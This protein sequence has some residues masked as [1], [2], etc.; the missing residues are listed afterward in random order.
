MDPGKGFRDNGLYAEIERRQR[1]VLAGG[2][3]TVVRPAEDN[4]LAQFLRP[5][6]EFGI[7]RREAV[8]RYLRNVR[9]EGKYLRPRG[10]YV[11]RGD[12]VAHLEGAFAGDLVLQRRGFRIILD[13][14]T[15]Q[16]FDGRCV[17]L[18]RRRNY[19]I[20]VH[21]EQLRDLEF[22]LIT[23]LARIGETAKHGGRRGDLGGDEIDL[24]VFRPAAA[25]E[26]PVERPE[27]YPAGVRRL[28]HADAG[29]A[30]AFKN[31][32]AALDH[33]IERAV[34]RYHVQYLLRS[35]RDGERHVR[36]NGLSVED[37]RHL[38]HI[39]KGTVGAGTDADLIDLHTGELRDL[40]HVI[41]RMRARRHGFE[42]RQI[43]LDRPVV[44]RAVVRGKGSVVALASFRLEETSRDL[45]RR[46]DRSR[47]AELGA[48][49]CDGRPLGNGKST[50]ALSGI[51]DYITDAA[52]DAHNPENFEDNVLG[53]YPVPEFSAEF[54]VYD[55]RV[56]DI[57]RAAAHS[58]RHVETARADGKHADAAAGGRVAVGADQRLARH[59]EAFKMDLVADAVS[60]SAEVD[61][62]LLRDGS[63]ES[64]V[65]SIFKAGLERVVV[66]VRD[67]FLRPDAW[68]PH[69]LE[70]Q[71]RHGAGGVLCQ[72]LVDPETD[73]RPFFAYPVNDVCVD[74]L[75]RKRALFLHIFRSF[76][77]NL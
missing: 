37:V 21:V 4:A 56:G 29:T 32:R 54:Y 19:H 68:D 39:V 10:H 71:I 8:L 30:C 57:V 5:R 58:Y 1:R 36:M 35:R 53:R 69:C 2:A 28:P 46:E 18:R 64:V 16:H 12:V 66:Y 74:Y 43:D 34:F 45:V 62:V 42:F 6:G 41:G 38:H 49:I 26:V 70:F 24:R 15:L 17:F 72:R 52:F 31:P 55:L 50:D 63:D 20:I 77:G 11:V 23:E 48:H 67:G 7:A 40:F 25:L 9:A 27:G 60:G 22:R 44:L 73:I 61:P 47:C 75:F 65:V 51:L 33:F 76:R 13:V 3:L 59:A 14:R